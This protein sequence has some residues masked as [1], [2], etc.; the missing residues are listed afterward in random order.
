MSP[1]GAAEPPASRTWPRMVLAVAGLV[2]VIGLGWL[3]GPG[4]GWVLEHFDGVAGLT[5]AQRAGAL[6]AIRG[7]ALTIVTGLAALVAVY[8]TARNADTS[9]RTFEIGQH[10]LALTEQGQVTER[11]TKAIE[12]LGS[13]DL[14]I[15]L[16]G[17]YALERI[18]RDSARDHSSVMEV[19]TA[20]V[21]EPSDLGVSSELSAAES[22]GARSG[23]RPVQNQG[24]PRLRGDIQAAITVIGRR[25]VEHDDPARRID[26]A[27]ANLAGADLPGARLANVD[28]AQANLEDA[29]LKNA[30]LSRANLW[31]A[32]LTRARLAE[33][34]LHSAIMDGATL[35]DTNLLGADLQGVDRERV[36]F[37][38]A[39]VDW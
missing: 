29:D 25:N 22:G 24:R 9:R 3:L 1:A 32:N 4:A 33:A 21:R 13:V 39:E 5:G 28:L 36:D 27:E 37:T 7:R 17:I 10:T 38:R 34:N 6:D 30:D 11:Y 26:L 19:L 20:F 16:G 31:K 8:F 15:R 35:A 23:H 14:A 12:Q 2:L 18:A